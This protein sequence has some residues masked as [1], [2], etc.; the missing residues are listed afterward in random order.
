MAGSI[1]A[2]LAQS[3]L[4]DRGDSDGEASSG[5]GAGERRRRRQSYWSQLFLM[6]AGSLFLA[7]NVAPTEEMVLISYMMG[8]AHVLAMATVS[9]VVM[10]TFVYAVEFSGQERTSPGTPFW[11]VF[12]RFTVVGYAVAL[13]ISAYVLW[14]FGRLD[15]TAWAELVRAVNSGEVSA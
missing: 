10:H 7:F 12:L 5:D 13:V 14:T 2:L 11:S 15:D 1:G 9:L 6:A 3:Q 8:P 4:G